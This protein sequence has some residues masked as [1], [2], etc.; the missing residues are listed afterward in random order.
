MNRF[1]TTIELRNE[2]VEGK[3]LNDLIPLLKEDGL[4]DA[5]QEHFW[6]VGYD[7]GLNL[8]AAVTVAIGD[9]FGVRVSIA[10]ILQVL[11]ASGSSRFYIGHNHPAGDLRPTAKDLQLTDQIMA[12]G[13]ICGAYLEDHWVIGPSQKVWS[14]KEKGQLSP[15]PG[16]VELYAE[17]GSPIAIHTRRGSR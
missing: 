13:S 12:A 15:S 11:H 16:I 7:A 14:M 6:V 8:R 4:F 3:T 1:F 17:A 10:A 5:A 9:Q 2:G